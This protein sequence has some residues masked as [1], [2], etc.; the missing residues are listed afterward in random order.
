MESNFKR[1]QVWYVRG[2]DSFGHE[3]AI[4]RPAV[5]IS[6]EDGA[7]TSPI[8]QMAYLTTKPRHNSISVEITSSKRRSWVLCEQLVTVDKRRLCEKLCD[9]AEPEMLK[10]ELGLRTA[11]GLSRKP[12]ESDALLK[13]RDEKICDLES[14]IA[15]LEL[16]LTVHKKLYER[17]L[18]EI[19]DRRFMKDISVEQPVVAV[20]DEP[21]EVEEPPK[22][23]EPELDL[24]G[25]SEKFKVYDERQKKVA[26]KPT[27]KVKVS[28]DKVNVNTATW[29]EIVKV[30]GIGEQTAQSIVCYRKK[31]GEYKD[32]TDLLNVPR[33]GSRVWDKCCDVLE[34]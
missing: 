30:T 18:S 13:E 22:M 19:V 20:E 10:V 28:K 29:E 9:L 12:S 32:L 27:K 33:V 21:F 16:E 31:N 25:L 24:S 26:E 8:L 3:E 6:S 7:R 4:G 17:A 11:L 23:E 34:V 5:I 2:D 14:K 15:E 1:G